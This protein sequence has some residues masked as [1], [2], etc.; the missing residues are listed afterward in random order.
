M[1][2]NPE[3]EKIVKNQ[4]E[5]MKAAGINEAPSNVPLYQG[6]TVFINR[7]PDTVELSFEF[8]GDKVYVGILA[9][10]KH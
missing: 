7:E 4:Y 6:L 8:E 5:A 2:L 1:G 9:N 10:D 3:I